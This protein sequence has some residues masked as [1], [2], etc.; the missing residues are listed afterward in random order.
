MKVLL[1]ANK[2]C[3]IVAYFVF[4]YINSPK[5]AIKHEEQNSQYL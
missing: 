5:G 2:K 1:I 4:P 3:L